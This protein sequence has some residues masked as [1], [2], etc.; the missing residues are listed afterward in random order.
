HGPLFLDEVGDLG[1]D[2]QAKL[3]RAIE[4]K[5]IQRV[6][7]KRVIRADVRIISATNHDLQRAVRAG[8][9]REDLYFRL[10]V[11]PLAI[12]PLRERGD[13]IL[14]LVEHFSGQ[15]LQRTGQAKPR[16]RSDALQ[17]LRDYPWAGHVRE[18]ANIVAR[19]AILQPG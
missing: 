11:I 2:E 4:G 1:P 18:L 14:E 5:E 6:G 3:R 12:P 7:G 19:R 17:L 9:F 8:A 13:D 15:F 16:W 10:Q